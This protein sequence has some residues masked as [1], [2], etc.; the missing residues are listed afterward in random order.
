MSMG[1]LGA[2]IETLARTLYGEARGESREGKI[3]VAWV[4]L[5]RARPGN[6]WPDSVAECCRQ[7]W[8]FSCW[9][10]NDPNLVKLTSVSLDK[11]SF[12]NCWVVA[13]EVIAGLHKDPTR[14]ANHYLNPDA[15]T[16][17]PSWYDPNKVTAT[18]GRHQ[19]LKL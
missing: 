16:T 17:M 10:T 4:V 2:D 5:N 19:F 6:P 11:P 14:G 3:A 9:N 8:Q 13:S 18:I 1:T 7:R 12:F 15:V